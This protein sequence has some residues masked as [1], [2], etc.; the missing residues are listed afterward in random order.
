MMKPRDLF[1]SGSEPSL[2]EMTGKFMVKLVIPFITIRLF[3]HTKVFPEGISKGYNRFLGFIRIARFTVSPGSPD[4][5]D[6]SISIIYDH[7]ENCFF[8]RRLTDVVRYSGNGLYIG[9]GLYRIFGKQINIFY[10]TLQRI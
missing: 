4:G 2:A 5:A 9:K 10:F 1:E 8:V 7:P 6:R 3:G